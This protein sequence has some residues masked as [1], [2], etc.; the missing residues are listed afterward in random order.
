MSWFFCIQ[1]LPYWVFIQCML[2]GSVHVLIKKNI[3]YQYIEG[4]THFVMPRS[5]KLSLALTHRNRLLFI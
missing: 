4:Q 3:L 1:H 5:A 2:V